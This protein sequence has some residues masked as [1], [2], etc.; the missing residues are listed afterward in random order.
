MSGTGARWPIL[1]KAWT[2]IRI[3]PLSTILQLNKEDI[4]DGDLASLEGTEIFTPAYF[5][6][7]NGRAL[8]AI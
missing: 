4:I 5:M 3:P 8:E 6:A 7:V 1:K 2:P